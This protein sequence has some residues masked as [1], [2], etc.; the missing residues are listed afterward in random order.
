MSAVSVDGSVPVDGASARVFVGW[1]RWDSVSRQEWAVALGWLSD[2]ERETGL[3]FADPVSG[4]AWLGGR[5]LLRRLLS[6]VLGG[7]PGGWEWEIA[8]D[9]RLTLAGR[10][11]IGV[12]LS[13]TR[14]VAVAAV[15][16]GG[17][18]GVDA[19][20]V[21]RFGGDAGRALSWCAW[22][23]WCKGSGMALDVVLARGIGPA[24]GDAARW[25]D[26]REMARRS[27]WQLARIDLP[28]SWA[29]VVAVGADSPVTV[30][31]R[32]VGF[33]TIRP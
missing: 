29:G 30:E 17:S 12:S 7:D 22:E 24:G 21:S 4:S 28:E 1:A 25:R 9:G 2:D 16:V 8:E 11:D 33:G 14:G 27:G 19:E 31:V 20:D 23:A 3:R 5:M 26:I 13:R 6:N 15:R 32:E 10:P 18:V